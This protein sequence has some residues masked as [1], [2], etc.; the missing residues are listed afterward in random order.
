MFAA[1]I[2]LGPVFARATDTFPAP[3]PSRFP[4]IELDISVLVEDTV[5]AGALVAA[6]HEAD[7]ALLSRVVVFDVYAG[8]GVEPGHLAVGL[9]LLFANPARTLRMEEAEAARTE[10]VSTLAA[11]FGATLRG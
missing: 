6:A 2:D 11:R 5:E 4:G 1:E 10:V 7:T 8:K 9:R 3:G